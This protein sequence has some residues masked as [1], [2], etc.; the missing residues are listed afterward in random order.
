MNWKKILFV[1]N[2]VSG[3]S[4]IKTVLSD[5]LQTLSG[6]EFIIECYP[7]KGH[8]DARRYVREL[9]G[10]YLYIVCAGG[11]GT[12]DEVVSGLM[13]NQA[14]P[15]LPVGYIP[16]GT[17]NDFAS[18]LGIPSDPL[19]AAQAVARG[20]AYVCDLGRFNRTDYFTY[21]A[22]FGIFT[23]T[24]YETPQ[25]LKR[26]L[27]HAAYL[28][29]G[30][31]ELGNI[32]TYHI[33]AETPE[34]SV[35]GDFAFG[36]VT[37]ARSVGGFEGIQGPDVDLQDGLFEATLIRLPANLLE[38]NELIQFFSGLIPETPLVWRR[39]VKKITFTSD[40]KIRWTRDGENGGAHR[41]VTLKN[42]Q[43]KFKILVPSQ[44]DVGHEVVQAANGEN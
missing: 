18:G 33:K 44:V 13:D 31:T 11:D 19:A 37:N 39:K 2:P 27:G 29:Q 36:M 17:T 6:A 23:E 16:L 7:T 4:Q 5:I 40:E 12:L 32:R 30:I 9:T 24:S 21:V 8:G 42:L 14:L 43:G 3:R 26:Q 28:L 34:E 22:A 38:I 25:E 20:R 10:D 41:K 35:E 15:M 1:Y